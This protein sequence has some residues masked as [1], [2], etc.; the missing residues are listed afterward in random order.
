MLSLYPSRGTETSHSSTFLP[1]LFIVLIGVLKQLALLPQVPW[2]GAKPG[3]TSS[4]LKQPSSEFYRSKGRFTLSTAEKENI[5]EVLTS[6]SKFLTCSVLG[7]AQMCVS[8][9]TFPGKSKKGFHS[10]VKIFKSLFCFLIQN[11]TKTP[12]TWM[13]NKCIFSPTCSNFPN[14]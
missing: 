11:L 8:L 7:A 14:S 6:G 4:F 9:F 3:R 5:A 10:S 13:N 12:D 2:Q 1:R